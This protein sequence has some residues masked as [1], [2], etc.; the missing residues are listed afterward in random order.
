MKLKKAEKLGNQLIDQLKVHCEKIALA[1][2]IRR[3]KPEVKDIEIVAQ[4]LTTR[5]DFIEKRLQVLEKKNR[6]RFVKSGGKYKSFWLIRNDRTTI[7]KVDLFLVTPPAQWGVIFMIR[8]GPDSFS[9]W[10]VSYRIPQ[11]LRFKDGAI[12][13]TVDSLGGTGLQTTIRFDTPSETQ[14]FKVLDIDFIK[15]KDRENY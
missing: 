14:V 5:Y 10:L 15:V 9:K 1:G 2:S 4:P 13:K 8:T 7:I 3:E 12:W 6:I 11:G